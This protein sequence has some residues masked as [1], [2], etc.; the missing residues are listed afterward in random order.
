MTQSQN[1]IPV[2]Q[3]RSLV[4]DAVEPLDCE[5][6]SLLEAIGRIS[7]S[8]HVSDIDISPFDH[9]AM[10]GFALVASDIENA[11]PE[12]PIELPVVA[13]VPAGDL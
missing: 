13:E 7:A 12:N 3:A 9:S 11:S 10:D 8:D 4:L 6:V 5:N 2:E 1:L